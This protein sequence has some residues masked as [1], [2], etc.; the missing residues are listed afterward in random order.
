[1]QNVALRVEVER[2]YKSIYKKKVTVEKLGVLRRMHRFFDLEGVCIKDC[3]L[4]Y[5]TLLLMITGGFIALW[6]LI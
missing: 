1:M 4:Y 5:G 6:A 2:K 3:I